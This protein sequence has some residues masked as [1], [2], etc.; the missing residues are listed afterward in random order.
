MK[1]EGY[2][3]AELHVASSSDL[4]N[5]TRLPS[6]LPT[7][8]CALTTYH[9]QLVLVGGVDATGRVT[10]KLWTSDAGHDWQ[11]S[12]PPMPTPRRNPFAINT[13]SPECLVV[14]SGFTLEVEMLI[15][16]QWSTVQHPTWEKSLRG[17]I[18]HNRRLYFNCVT[19]IHH[20]DVKKLIASSRTDQPRNT[21]SLWSEIA[22][23][24]FGRLTSFGQQLVVLSEF[25]VQAYSPITQS[26]MHVCK[27]VPGVRR[28][29]DS[30]LL[31]TGDLLVC[32]K[33]SKIEVF[34]ATLNGEMIEASYSRVLNFDFR[35]LHVTYFIICAFHV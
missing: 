31:P 15:G 6:D 8:S 20:C 25:D 13:V 22:S 28:V 23:P 4:S 26:W 12:L 30:V 10:N 16:K 33:T 11:P 32:L 19:A 2:T 17:S 35:N 1:Y 3:R 21:E 29:C 34:Q 27:A 14:V 5:W 7:H 24:G 9:S 18:L